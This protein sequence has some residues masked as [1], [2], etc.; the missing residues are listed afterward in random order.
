VIHSNAVDQRPRVVGALGEQS[1]E[2]MIFAAYRLGARAACPIPVP[3]PRWRAWANATRDRFANRCLPILMAD[4]AGWVIPSPAVVEV[5]WRGGDGIDQL[6][7]SG[8]SATS[9]CPAFSHFGHGILTWTIPFLFRT[10]PG[11]NLLVRGPAN[12]PKDGIAPLEGLVE[13]DWAMSPFTMNWKVTRPNALIR[14]EAGEP[15]CMLVPQRR[16]ELE[17][18]MP[19]VIDLQDSAEINEHYRVWR[20]SRREFNARL[21]SGPVEELWQKHYFRGETPSGLRAQEHQTRLRLHT[22]DEAGA[23]A[24]EN[25]APKAGEQEREH[26]LALDQDGS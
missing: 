15:I 13:T 10:P 17:A 23:D 7:V 21:K 26:G 20:K 16:G 3:A 24:G 9:R 19:V 18:F 5:M 8:E 25:A 22:F 2:G 11:Y 6:E 4:Q 12:S 1:D 14:F